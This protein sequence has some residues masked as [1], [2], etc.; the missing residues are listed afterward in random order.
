M[1][2][3]KELGRKAWRKYSTDGVAASGFNMPTTDDIF[4]YVDEV[5]KQLLNVA[6]LAAT[7]R[8]VKEPVRIAITTNVTLST[9]VNGFV[10]QGLTLATGDRIAP[11]G[12]SD[13]A[14]NGIRIVQASG[15]PIRTTDADSAT[16]LLGAT[17]YVEDGTNAG[18]TYSCAAVAPIV[19][20]T[21]ALPFVLG[22]D[23]S[24]LVSKTVTGSG[25]ADGSGDEIGNNPVI[26]VP[27][28]TDTS[29]LDAG[30]DAA[31][32]TPY[33]VNVKFENDIG[34]FVTDERFAHVFAR[35]P[36][37]GVPLLALNY[38]GSLYVHGFYIF[39]SEE[40][41]TGVF[42]EDGTILAALKW[43][44]LGGEWENGPFYEM[45]E[46]LENAVAYID[47]GKVYALTDRVVQLTF[48]D[49][50][51]AAPEIDRTDAVY[52]TID[53][54]IVKVVREDLL[55]E[56]S[57][58]DAITKVNG[59]YGLTQSLGIGRESLPALTT[60]PP[61]PDRIVMHNVGVRILG[62]GQTSTYV[63]TTVA[64]GDL[65]EWVPAY[66]QD[67]STSGE[68]PFS[69]MAI[70][71]ADNSPS[72]EAFVISATGIGGVG[73]AQMKKGTVPYSNLIA[74]IK[75]DWIMCQT[76]GVDFEASVTV[77]LGQNDRNAASGV[78]QGYL[79][80]YQSDITADVQ[81]IVPGHGEVVLYV[82]QLANYTA[83][84]Y[85]G[86]FSYVPDDIDAAARDNPDK[87][88]LVGPEYTFQTAADGV[89]LINEAS[90]SL[91]DMHAGARLR[92]R[93]NEPSCFRAMTA[94]RTGATI[95]VT[96]EVPV[97]P[98][99]LNP[100]VTD[101]AGD[102]GIIAGV[103]KGLRYANPGAPSVTISTITP[104]S[105][106]LTIV[107][108][109]NPGAYNAGEILVIGMDGASGAAGGP[110]TGP[111]TCFCDSDPGT[112]PYGNRANPLS[113]RIVPVTV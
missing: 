42:A 66:E 82:S 105:T 59:L 63:D 45:P 11:I 14:T 4:P 39:T 109:S 21:T 47:D 15:T 12:Q 95:V 56:N 103:V 20:G 84:G 69:G 83:P 102:A 6:S 8:Q 38:D 50:T 67:Q 93:D 64:R 53:G 28:A 101:P 79:E 19:L 78:F 60:D 106:T 98:I 87:I 3:T 70:R 41:E 104:G 58:A 73:Y 25:L 113:M 55:A 44:A 24:A 49:V 81:A 46:R 68:T 31:A 92:Y 76:I 33:T 57:L 48:G 97:P 77:I 1:A 51:P 9:L 74:C 26:D 54:G 22:G 43:P 17:F 88:V 62:N 75:R 71:L 5:D 23:D 89:H 27:K 110:T 32:V 16:D 52:R 61:E 100:D 80:E 91:G 86:T 30:Q 7:G 36:V 13:Q 2:T 108:S 96:C 35:D 90:R 18:K 112:H 107:L 34:S 65:V 40:Y 10:T 37:T 111:R 94:V 72:D 29:V 99:I 85:D